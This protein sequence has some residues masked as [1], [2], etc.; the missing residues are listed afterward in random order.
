MRIKRYARLWV[1]AAVLVLCVGLAAQQEPTYKIRVNVDLV[2]ISVVA[3]DRSGRFVRDLTRDDFELMEDRRPQ[4]LSAVDLETVGVSNGGDMLGRPIELPILSSAGSVVSSAARG[5]RL[6][7]LF[8]DFTSLDLPGAARSLRAA[9]AYV[10]TIG[11]ADRIAVVSLRPKLEVQQDFTG[12]QEKLQ[13][14]LKSL[15]GFSQ[16][17][18]DDP[19]DRSYKLFYGYERLRSLRVLAGLLANIPQKKSVVIFTGGFDSDSDLAGVTATVDAAARSGISFYGVDAA[20]L[21]ANPPLGDAS[22]ASSL[23]T[24]VLSGVT[25][26]QTAGTTRNQDLLHALAHGT[27]GRAFFDSNDFEHPFRA[28]EADSSE[29]YLLSY[30]S[31]NSSRDG[32]FR[33]ISVHVHRGGIQLKHLA[34]YYGPRDVG[35]LSAQDT[36]RLI[37]E[38][39]AAD[40][41]STSLPVYGFVNHLRVD[42]D[43]YF[44]PITVVVPAEALLNNGSGSAAEVGLAILDSRGHVVRQL[45]D[46]IPTTAFNKDP[47]CAVQYETAAELPSGEYNLRLVVVRNDFGQVGSFSTA[48]RL[49]KP[50]HSRLSVSPPLSGTLTAI[51][52]NSPKSPLVVNGSRLT[53]NPL[54]TFKADRELTVQ[55]QVECGPESS[56]SSN[57]ACQPKETRS[58]LQCFLSDQPVFKVVPPAS[59]ISRVSAVFRVN[60]PAGSLRPGTYNCRVTAINSPASAFAFGSIQLRILQ[61]LQDAS[62][63]LGACAG[64]NVVHSAATTLKEASCNFGSRQ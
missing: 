49:P 37:A 58:S 62:G 20:G 3:L 36:E 57:A 55:Y 24:G 18:L 6:V 41:P 17:A 45:R 25:V 29:Y 51:L 5:L 22:R 4:Q 7:V 35:A 32:R 47:N 34:G 2:Q 15:H 21:T 59:K 1:S 11:P 63:P 40:L 48:I 27:G 54:S 42:Q 23:G 52:P 14:V 19:G 31:S 56:H 44:L 13:R 26:A 39:L 10:Q 8:F 50:D 9:E 12:D 53:V 33:H 60:F 61:E 46:V 30:H 16:E 28:L 38:E 43:L 64:T